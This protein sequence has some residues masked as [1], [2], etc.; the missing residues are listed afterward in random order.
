MRNYFEDDRL[1][2]KASNMICDLRGLIR[3]AYYEG[4]NTR[5]FYDG[6]DGPI[7]TCLAEWAVSTA[8]KDSIKKFREDQ[9]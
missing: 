5:S 1:L 8:K 6:F 3:E 2:E 7:P 9:K 4:W